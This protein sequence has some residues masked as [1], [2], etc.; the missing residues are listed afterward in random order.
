MSRH[1]VLR[2]AA[3]TGALTTAL[4]LTA[5]AGSAL[6]A[7]AP[8][9]YI[10]VGPDGARTYS[11]NWLAAADDGSELVGELRG[12]YLGIDAFGVVSRDVAAGTTSVLVPA[13]AGMDAASKDRK[14][15]IFHTTTSYS[16]KDTNPFRDYYLLDRNTGAKTLLSADA[17]GTAIGVENDGAQADGKGYRSMAK[18]SL[19]GDG[20]TAQFLYFEQTNQ[21]GEP[22]AIQR[23]AWRVNV[24]T[25]ARTPLPA[26]S[27]DE[28]FYARSMDDAG[29]VAINPSSIYID[30][31]KKYATPTSSQPENRVETWVVSP[32]GDFA[33]GLGLYRDRVIG[34]DL[35]N[36]NTRTI[37]FSTYPD[38]YNLRL[39]HVANDGGSV[40][41][42]DVFG[43]DAKEH[44][45]VG[46][47]DGS[48]LKQLGDDIPLTDWEW[49]SG[50]YQGDRIGGVT[51]DGAFAYTGL[52]LAKLGS[53]P[54]PGAE[55]N[56]PTTA[57]APDYLFITDDTCLRT[58]SNWQPPIWNKANVTL[59][60]KPQKTDLRHAVSFKGT[61]TRTKTGVV[62]QNLQL[63][64]GKPVDLQNI[65]RNGGFKIE[66]V[67][68]FSDGTTLA[69]ATTIASHAAP[70]YCAWPWA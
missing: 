27:E 45:A 15:I 4:L 42:T 6:A 67:V 58:R 48:G 47:I 32:N 25:L 41:V 52:N 69:G 2:C 30:G 12:G 29:R 18:P 54:L 9:R 34:I 13:P 37:P 66:G 39:R 23:S 40:I 17:A 60:V 53:K 51:A 28:A 62:T 24:D 55:P 16:P 70:G 5:S 56:L 59:A 63:T 61:V 1:S 64:P 46:R 44:M 10:G 50:E 38:A 8:L 31:V 21:P 68:T 65:G 19:S 22:Y 35:R 43:R 49:M 36:G 14:R 20:K 26:V 57:V 11:T 33:A 7:T 3:R